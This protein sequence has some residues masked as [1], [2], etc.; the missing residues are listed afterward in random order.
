MKKKVPQYLSSP[1]QLLWFETD[2]LVVMIVFFVLALMFGG[3]LWVMMFVVPFI[4]G[5]VKHGYSRGFIKHLM[6]FSGLV[7]I[8]NYPGFWDSFFVE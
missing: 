2:D 4:Y 8:K 7:S 3:W 5:K 1:Y 6:Y